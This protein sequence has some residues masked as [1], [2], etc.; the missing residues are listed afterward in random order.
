M[1]LNDP[2]DPDPDPEP[3]DTKTDEQVTDTDPHD[4][5]GSMH[6]D[7]GDV[8][9][10]QGDDRPGAA[11]QGEGAGAEPYQGYTSEERLKL[12]LDQY[13][14]SRASIDALHARTAPMW[15]KYRNM[16]QQDQDRLMQDGSVSADQKLP[17]MP[18]QQK[19]TWLGAVTQL[20]SVVVP[21]A[22]MFG[23]RGN[24]FA[25]GAMMSAMGAFMTNYAKGRDEAAKQN[26]T[27]YKDQVAAIKASNQERHQIYKD[28]LA[29]RRLALDDQ[30]KMIHAVAQEFGDPTMAKASRIKDMRAIIKHLQNQDKV[31]KSYEKG[32][33]KAE[34]IL[35]P[36][37][38]PEY[39]QYMKDKYNIDPETDP[40]GADAKKKYT[41]WKED[42]DTTADRTRR[43]KEEDAQE[44]KEATDGPSSEDTRK[45]LFGE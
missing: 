1:A 10:P 42:E 37:D 7:P 5:S 16:L 40:V 24:G 29:N 15:E 17:Q 44:K 35:H 20:L 27:E 11:D 14:R 19:Q 3:A 30:F 41:D 38:W 23:I 28:T 8:T 43:H 2:N 21:V 13:K 18:S 33:A 39:R 12:T 34:K 45:A 25:K 36:K 32:I 6:T 26:W 9:P 31:M 4:K 22:M